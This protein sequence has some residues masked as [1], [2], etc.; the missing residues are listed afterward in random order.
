MDSDNRNRDPVSV[1]CERKCYRTIPSQGR[2]RWAGHVASIEELSNSCKILVAKPEG[3]DDS[4]NL[5]VDREII[6]E[7]ILGKQGGKYG[8]DAS[9]SG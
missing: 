9:G 8:L 7:W 1:F 5:D 3:K 6:L 4:E 2:G